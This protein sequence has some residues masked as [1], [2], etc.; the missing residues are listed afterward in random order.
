MSKWIKGTQL[1]D[2][3][4]GRQVKLTQDNQKLYFDSK[5]SVKEVAIGSGDFVRIKKPVHVKKGFP[6]FSPPIRV[7]DV[8]GNSVKLIN[9]QWWNKSLSEKFCLQ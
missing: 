2:E 3:S 6:K 7:T 9:G 5:K 4:V 8:R 1:S